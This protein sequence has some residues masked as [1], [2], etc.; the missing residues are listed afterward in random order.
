MS[1][2]ACLNNFI[3]ITIA[4]RVSRA[5]EYAELLLVFVSISTEAYRT[6]SK[7][8]AEQRFD[9]NWQR[10]D[11]SDRWLQ[12]GTECLYFPTSNGK[13]FSWND[14][15]QICTMHIAKSL[16]GTGVQM[17]KKGV[18]PVILNSPAK[19]R[20]L[21]ELIDT[22]KEDGYAIQLSKDYN[23]K[24]G[25]SKPNYCTK[26]DII[27]NEECFS[28]NGNEKTM[29]IDQVPCNNK[30]VRLACEYTLPGKYSH[31][32]HIT[33]SI[34]FVHDDEINTQS[35]FIDLFVGNDEIQKSQFKKCSRKRR[36]SLSWYYIVSICFGIIFSLILIVS[37]VSLF[38]GRKSKT[39]APLPVLS[40]N[41]ERG[42][43]LYAVCNTRW[44]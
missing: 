25:E 22:Y 30:F 24:C 16:R 33:R 15:K 19:S 43:K 34:S 23:D 39:K 18:R 31:T 44:L 12:V 35:I 13:E 11:C 38:R 1:I 14:I 6:G 9:T 41:T 26:P 3:F 27:N 2:N 17:T 29:C 10:G 28:T 40:S 37:A 20:L 42:T 21:Q 7:R 4:R 8:P 5:N 32:E 36:T